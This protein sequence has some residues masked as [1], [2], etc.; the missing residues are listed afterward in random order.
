MAALRRHVES[1]PRLTCFAVTDA[2]A[3]EII[4]LP[5]PTVIILYGRRTSPSMS[6][7]Y[8]LEG[9]IPG[10]G[11][12]LRVEENRVVDRPVTFRALNVRS[13]ASK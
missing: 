9:L 7:S 3:G 11:A 4:T 2:S 8:C 5:A 12:G 1:P 13:S 6:G 10:V